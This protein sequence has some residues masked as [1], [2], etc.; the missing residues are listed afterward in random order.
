M[1]VY[2]S[3]CVVRVL[4]QS[5]AREKR[6]KAR[7]ETARRASPFLSSGNHTWRFSAQAVLSSSPRRCE[8]STRRCF[9][10]DDAMAPALSNGNKERENR[11]EERERDVARRKMREAMRIWGCKRVTSD[12]AVM[13]R[14]ARM[15]SIRGHSTAQQPRPD[16]QN[17]ATPKV[18]EHERRSEKDRG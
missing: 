7:G 8:S 6:N 11:G 14:H 5:S 3:M 13:L 18:R 17:S 15:L 2:L 9:S 16:T 10:T 1:C 12:G 4:R